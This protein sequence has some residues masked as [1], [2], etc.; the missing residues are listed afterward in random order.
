[1][2]MVILVGSIFTHLF[3]AETT[4]SMCTALEILKSWVSNRFPFLYVY[5]IDIDIDID[6]DRSIDR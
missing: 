1:M 3:L 5:T 2:G 4:K 6:I